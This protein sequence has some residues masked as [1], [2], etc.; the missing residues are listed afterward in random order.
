MQP[1]WVSPGSRPVRLGNM[2]WSES[3]SV[4]STPPVAA[5]LLLFAVL[6]LNADRVLTAASTATTKSASALAVS[7]ARKLT[8]DRRPWVGGT[9]ESLDRD[10]ETDRPGSPDAETRQAIRCLT[11]G[12]APVLVSRGHR[13]RGAV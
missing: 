7:R 4:R 9:G 13:D 5:L 11:A 3:L 2:A 10:M 12:G 1:L 6:S 8:P